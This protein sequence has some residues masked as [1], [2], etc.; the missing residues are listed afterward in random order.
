MNDLGWNCFWEP[1]LDP[2]ELWNINYEVI[3]RAANKLCPMVKMKINNNNLDWFSHDLLQE[4]HYKEEL[5]RIY[6]NTKDPED[7]AAFKEQNI[8]VKSQ[9][10]SGKEEFVKE[11]LKENSGNP[12]KF[13]RTI[14]NLTGLGKNKAKT[15]NI[16]I[17]TAEGKFLNGSEAVEHINDYYVNVGPKLAEK[18]PD[19]WTLPDNINGAEKFDFS[20]TSDYEVLKMV[21]DVK[22]SKSSAFPDL[23]TRLFKDAFEKIIPELTHLYN[24]CI[25]NSI[26]PTIWG[27]AE[28][29]PIPKTGNLSKVENWRPISQIKLPGKILE[30]IL[31]R[32]L[33]YFANSILH[34]NQHGFRANRSTSTAI[35]DVMQNLF[36]HWNDNKYISC[37][38]IDYSIAFD[39]LDHKILLKKLSAYGLEENS[40]KLMNS[41]FVN[42]KQRTKL[43]S[44][45]STYKSLTYGVPQGSILGPLLF[46]I[47]TNDLFFEM[48]SNESTF[49]Y[50]DDTLIMST[51]NT[52]IEAI[53]NSQQQ[54]NI[55]TAWC[56]CNKLTINISK[57]KHMCITNK[58]TSPNLSISIDSVNL[59]N[60]STFE[61]LG[62]VIDNKL[63][64]NYQIDNIFK[65]VSSKL[66]TFSIIIR[67][68]S[69]KI[70]LLTYT[71]M[72]L[73]HFDYVDF[74]LDSATNENTNKLER[75][76]KRAL[77]KI[78]LCTD[79]T[80]KAEYTK[81]LK[82]YGLTT[83]Y[84]RRAEHLLAFVFKY[85][86][87]IIAIDPQKPKIELRSK[88]KVKL[89]CNFTSKTKV[90]N[91]PLHRGVLLWN[92]L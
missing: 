1:N 71:V 15:T 23:S 5:F 86:N 90:Q 9:I 80:Q 32:Q 66:Y 27:Y 88:N 60:V 26:F 58:K 10:K 53:L 30:R 87:D 70:A 8:F 64:M 57:T 52:E 38:F 28:V 76:H 6:K 25:R 35:F 39:T 4:I 50:A 91:S 2:N 3:L 31:H 34:K 83:L 77:R 45:T 47:Y 92:K 18:F 61:Y 17:K 85:K 67:F 56:R 43:E 81:I 42:R 72:I 40:I 63:K 33:T 20:T 75:L 21:K 55:L 16:Q 51:G 68:L 19:N 73:P 59:A 82:E 36:Q 69:Q 48:S 78:E 11:S 89:K 62:I 12:R 65:K 44:Q 24:C 49:M 29:S 14:N 13:W 22:I 74:I 79:Y 7:W 84:Q 46:I 54:L 41:H 37:V